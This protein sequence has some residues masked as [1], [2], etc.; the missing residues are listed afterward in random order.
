VRSNMNNQKNKLINRI[1]DWIKI[2]SLI[3]GIISGSILVY[4]WWSRQ[5]KVEKLQSQLKEAQ[6]LKDQAQQQYQFQNINLI[7]IASLANSPKIHSF[8]T[9]LLTTYAEKFAESKKLD[10]SHLPLKFEGLYSDPKTG[11]GFGEMGRCFPRQII[12]PRKEKEINIK[13]NRLYLL[14]KFGHD[15]YFATSPEQSGDYSYLEISFEEMI[16]TCC[17][18]LA[19]YI[20]LVKHGKSS[21]ESDLKLNNG[22]YDEELDQEHKKFTEEI[23]QLIKNSG[24]YSEWEKKWKEIG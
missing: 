15:R 4:Q 10:I 24:E 23:Y 19:H 8:F 13:L 2:T 20:Q 17:H 7:S 18:E 6:K 12:Y 9:D 1:W 21:C 14:N 11:N 3:L 5:Q 22:K 16:N